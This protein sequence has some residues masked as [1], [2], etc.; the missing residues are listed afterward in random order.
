MAA[1]AAPVDEL[2]ARRGHL[3]EAD[4]RGRRVTAADEDGQQLGCLAGDGAG[5]V[6]AGGGSNVIVG[7]GVAT[8]VEMKK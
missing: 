7:E 8:A 3:P 6:H 4:T 1:V 5:L 2:A